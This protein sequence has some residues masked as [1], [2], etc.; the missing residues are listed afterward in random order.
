SLTLGHTTGDAVAAERPFKDAGFDSLAAVELRNRLGGELGITLPATLVF[1]YPTPAAMAEFLDDRMRPAPTDGAAALLAE[2]DRFEQTI[3]DA[4]LHDEL[5]AQVAKRLQTLA[6]SWASA[7]PD[8][9]ATDL[10]LDL[11]SDDE[12]FELLD[13]ELGAP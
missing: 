13:D 6:G 3:A 4:T 8:G 2:L 12:I 7:G 9:E 5:R 10:D 11:A 1:D